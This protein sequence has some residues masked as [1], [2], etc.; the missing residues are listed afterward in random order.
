MA[1]ISTRNVLQSVGKGPEVAGTSSLIPGVVRLLLSCFLQ[2]YAGANIRADA[3]QQY[4]ISFSLMDGEITEGG[5]YGL[6]VDYWDEATNSFPPESSYFFYDISHD[7]K[8]GS[9][10][11]SA[12][13]ANRRQ[14]AQVSDLA[15]DLGG[16]HDRQQGR[17][18]SL[19]QA[20]CPCHA[21][22]YPQKHVIKL[23]EAAHP[24]CTSLKVRGCVR[25]RS[26]SRCQGS[27]APNR[28]CRP[29]TSCPACWLTSHSTLPLTIT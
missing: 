25:C 24:Y 19:L 27:G 15:C 2:L 10:T 8:V 1:A 29:T 17:N 20:P 18:S 28:M 21:D 23:I 13:M 12:S 5:I 26:P 3:T 11:P 4:N 14:D 9:M 6:R 16:S 7:F 22:P